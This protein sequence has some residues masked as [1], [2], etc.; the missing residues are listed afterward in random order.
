MNRIR[1]NPTLHLIL[2]RLR[3]LND[4][5]KTKMNTLLT[6]ENVKRFQ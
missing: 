4:I 3:Q 2:E 5:A 6:L 1:P